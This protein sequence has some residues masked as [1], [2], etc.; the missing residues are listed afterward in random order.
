LSTVVDDTGGVTSPT[1]ARD[2]EL[3]KI[4]AGETLP[5]AAFINTTL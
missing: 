5:R 1:A 2:T 4:V 3:S